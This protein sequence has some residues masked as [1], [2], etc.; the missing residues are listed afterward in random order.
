MPSVSG[1]DT[2]EEECNEGNGDT[3]SVS[4][5]TFCGVVHVV[6]AFGTAL[7]FGNQVFAD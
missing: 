1:A 4:S 2:E 3:N 5:V 6:M 7:I